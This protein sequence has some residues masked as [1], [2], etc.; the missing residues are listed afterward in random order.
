[1]AT[2]MATG[3]GVAVAVDVSSP[4]AFFSAL[5]FFTYHIFALPE[6]LAQQGADFRAGI[7]T[8][9]DRDGDR[10]GG[11]GGRGGCE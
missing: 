1:M 9:S 3:V 8:D 2:G 6:L 5:A 7:M 4:P 11:Y 10:G